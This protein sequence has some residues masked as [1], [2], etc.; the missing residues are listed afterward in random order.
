ILFVGGVERNKLDLLPH[1]GEVATFLV[2]RDPSR[3][4]ILSLHSEEVEVR[5]AA[6]VHLV[7][8]VQRVE[9][10]FAENRVSKRL[11]ESLLKF[12]LTTRVVDVAQVY[13]AS[14]AEPDDVLRDVSR[15]VVART[16][17]GEKPDAGGAVRILRKIV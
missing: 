1:Q 6:G 11:D 12:L 13:R 17:V 8:G 15:V 16:P 9:G 7:I 14:G 2:L 4:R 5:V 3:L 10:H